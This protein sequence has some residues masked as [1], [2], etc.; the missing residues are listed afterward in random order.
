MSIVVVLRNPKHIV[1][2][3]D[4]QK[5]YGKSQVK[6]MA[7]RKLFET[8]H[9]IG[10]FVGDDSA[11]ESLRQAL[12]RNEDPASI[13]NWP[14]ESDWSIYYATFDGKFYEADSPG[15]LGWPQD[16]FLAIGSGDK[17]AYGAFYAYCTEK[18][19]RK[20]ARCSLKTLQAIAHVC[21]S[22]AIQCDKNCGGKVDMSTLPI[23]RK[24]P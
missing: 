10:G 9:G 23:P 3:A 22:A 16:N 21:V 12:T 13:V 2:A 11:Q 19:I 20:L 17:F 8:P 5:T 7:G 15:I 4:E 6:S 24:T 14:S 1:F 18:K